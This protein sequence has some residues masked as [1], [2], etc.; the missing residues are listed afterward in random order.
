VSKLARDVTQTVDA[1]ADHLAKNKFINL[2]VL[3]TLHKT[4]RA[5]DSKNYDEMLA[6]CEQ[7]HFLARQNGAHIQALAHCK[8]IQHDDPF[9]NF[10][11]SVE[12]RGEPDTNVVI[13][14]H[15]GKR[16]IKSETRMGIPWEDPHVLCAETEMVDKTKMVKRFYLGDTTTAIED[17]QTAA[18]EKN[19]RAAI[20]NGIVT[21]LKEHGGEYPMTKCLDAIPGN[22]GLKNE[23]RDELIAD[24]VITLRGVAHSKTN[25]SRLVLVKPDW[26]GGTVIANPSPQTGVVPIPSEP[27]AE[28]SP[29]E[30]ERERIERVLNDL[31]SKLARQSIPRPDI[32]TDITMYQTQL[33]A[34]G[35]TPCV[36]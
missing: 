8:K 14:D 32:E 23:V 20:A 4:I 30:L 27:D 21:L 7:L 12:L 13:Y 34:M 35:G 36:N 18:Q 22:D 3:D 29:I 9:D 33:D 24:D 1:I 6:L 15:R 17:H 19:T 28:K 2:V 25:P 11:G 10:L 16:L 5:T 26:T 31:R